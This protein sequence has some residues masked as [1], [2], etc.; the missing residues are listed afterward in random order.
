MAIKIDVKA[1]HLHA[2]QTLEALNRY[3]DFMDNMQQVSD[4][5][6]GLGFDAAWW[7]N[8]TKQDGTPRSIKVNAVDLHIDPKFVKQHPNVKYM[9]SDYSQTSI[10]HN[11]QDLIWAHNSFQY[12]TNPFITLSH[13]WDLLKVDGMLL[14]TVP[15]TFDIHTHREIQNVDVCHEPNTYY[16]WS[17]GSL[18][19]SLVAN[20]FDCRQSHFRLDKQNG[21]LQAAVYKLAVRPPSNITYYDMVDQKMLP[22]SIESAIMKN[23][24][25]NE[26]DIVCDW[27]DRSQYILAL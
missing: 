4:M 18:I 17:L 27:I 16:N 19:L 21:W 26:T 3:Q 13:W 24:H 6:C 5:G 7:A 2:L 10:V 9:T 8:L 14:I 25:F 1:S 23:G 11:S 22:L 15:Y 12:A 20:G